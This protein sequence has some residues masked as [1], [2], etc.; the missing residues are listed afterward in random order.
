MS[1]INVYLLAAP[2][3]ALEIERGAE[4]AV[5]MVLVAQIEPL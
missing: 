3:T 2:P 1:G 5:G 4:R